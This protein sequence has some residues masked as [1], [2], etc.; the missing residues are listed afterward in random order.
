MNPRYSGDMTAMLGS[1]E[2]MP[3]AEGAAADC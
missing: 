2:W 1:D 3:I